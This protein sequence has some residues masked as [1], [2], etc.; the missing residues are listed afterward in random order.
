M[1]KEEIIQKTIE[2]TKSKLSGEGTGH[3]WWHVYRVW[4]NAKNIAEKEKAN[5]FVV[6]LSAL[7][8]DIADWKFNDGDEEIGSKISR[9]W[10]ESLSVD[11]E[12]IDQVCEIIANS[13]FKGAGVENKINTLEGKILQDADR[14]DAIGAIGIARAFA[15]GGSKNRE[16]YNPDIKPEFHTTSEQYKNNKST[17]INHFYE[18]LL[19]LKDLM[20]TD[21][22]KE[23]AKERHEFMELFL[24]KFKKEW[25]CQ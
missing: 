2:Y 17:T 9:D 21:T 22:A 23:I 6:E 25:D 3:D 1:N 5:S 12:I 8:H 14:L 18:K 24:N 10:L 13:S 16:I 15:Y 7:L 19:L 20:H 11:K 4:K